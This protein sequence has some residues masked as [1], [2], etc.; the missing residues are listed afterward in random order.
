MSQP[1]LEVRDLTKH[2][3]IRKGVF[4][5]T[6]GHVR[7]VDGVSF[8][9]LRGETFGLVGESGC[10][11]STTGRLI[12]RLIEPSAGAIL[13]DGEDIARL[14]GEALRRTRVDFQMVFQDPYGSRTH[15]ERSSMRSANRSISIGSARAPIAGAA[16][17][18]S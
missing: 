16:P 4:S 1:L 17:L 2:F 13:F 3:P 6:V 7:A 15:A 10:G 9:I 12:I 14:D 5:R 8:S 11:K 18:N